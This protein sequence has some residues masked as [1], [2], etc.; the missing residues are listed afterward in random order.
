MSHEQK[1]APIVLGAQKA[2]QQFRGEIARELGIPIRND[3]NK[4][5]KVMKSPA[6]QGVA[7][8]MIEL[9]EQQIQGK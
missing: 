4:S 9:A 3:E 5:Y 1:K 8:R 2:S 6:I 7:K